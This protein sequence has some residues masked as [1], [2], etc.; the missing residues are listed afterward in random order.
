LQGN[1]IILLKNFPNANHQHSKRMKVKTIDGTYDANDSPV[2]L[3]FE[4][5]KEIQQMSIQLLQMAPGLSRYCL[6]PDGMSE[7]QVTEFMEY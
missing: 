5:G 3:V 7:E 2:M 4:N 1:T 6:Y